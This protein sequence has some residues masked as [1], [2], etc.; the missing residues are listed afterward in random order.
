[1]TTATPA[2]EG[3]RAAVAAA[4]GGATVRFPLREPIS[5][6]TLARLSVEHGLWFE[7]GAEGEI[8]ITGPA[9][10]TAPEDTFE[11]NID[12]G[13]WVRSL[14]LGKGRDSQGGYDPPLGRRW[15][16]DAGWLS[17]ETLATLSE[18]DKRGPYWPVAPDFV[19]EVVSPSQSLAAQREKMR[20][21]IAAEVKLGMLISPDDELVEL[22]RADGSIETFDCPE[23]VSCDPV[24]PGFTLRFDRIWRQ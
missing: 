13:I 5:D 22:Y 23:S 17:D 14:N 1:M 6:E 21:W 8:I 3:I 10:G 19:V 12:I 18:T 2:L 15:V 24:M 20:A 9:G 11:V 7:D 16:P 4:R